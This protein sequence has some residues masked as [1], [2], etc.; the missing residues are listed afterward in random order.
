MPDFLVVGLE[1]W[2]PWKNLGDWGTY[3]KIFFQKSAYFWKKI[4]K[5][6]SKSIILPKKKSVPEWSGKS[7]TLQEFLEFTPLHAPD[8]P[9]GV[10]SGHAPKILERIQLHS[11]PYKPWLWVIWMKYTQNCLSKNFIFKKLTIFG[12]RE[13]WKYGTFIIKFLT[14]SDESIMTI[15]NV[16]VQAKLFHTKFYF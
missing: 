7:L 10:N 8:W 15:M 9:T 14:L 4:K 12:I 6:F 16:K 13:A 1:R 5:K 3:V 11:A 2:V